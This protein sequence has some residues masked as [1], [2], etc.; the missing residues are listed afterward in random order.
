M[1]SKLF[2]FHFP[3][4]IFSF[5][6]LCLCVSAVSFSCSSKPTNLRALVP[7]DALVYLE[8]NDL[9]AALQPIIDS[10]PFGEVAKSKPDLSA[11]RGVQL[12]VAVTGFETKE[13]KITE[14]NSIGRIQPHFAAIA[15]THA[16]SWQ[17]RNFA[18]NQ[19][20]ELINNIYGGGVNLDTTPKNGGSYYVWTAEDG[21]KA[22]ALVDGSL[23]FFGNDESSIEKC[24]AVKR[25]EADSILK[26]SKLPPADPNSLAQGYVSTDG[27]AQIANIVGIAMASQTGEEEEVKSFIASIL[28]QILRSSVIDVSW[29][30]TKTEQGIEDKYLIST[31]PDVT[32]V[33]SETMAPSERADTLLLEF[34]P[35]NAP[36]VTLY[37]LKD[38]QVAWRSVLLVIQKQTD[39]TAGKLLAGFSSSLFEPYGIRDPE[40]F[41]KSVGPTIVSAKVDESGEKPVVIA[42]IKKVGELQRS[43][44]TDVGKL[45]NDS[46][47]ATSVQSGIGVSYLNNRVHLGDAE[48]VIGCITKET[49]SSTRSV[50][51]KQQLGE[52]KAS[53][54]T[55]GTDKSAASDIASAFDIKKYENASGKSKFMIETRFTKNGI[56]RKTVSDFGLI[57]S[58]IAQLA[59]EE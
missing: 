12:A 28:P 16:W 46:P 58:I 41:L 6:A 35:T 24:L 42:P 15:D 1:F 59:P 54:V 23:I 57:G 9:G 50:Q 5:L 33:L 52:A 56:E 7:S 20:G 14:E 37:N 38:P 21:R 2:I 32:N 4:S 51:L 27:V 19:L 40:L 48:S 3:F 49:D 29:V 13:E 45:S 39:S 34:L 53:V 31:V 10:K 43:I 22:Y 11:L 17:T 25:G 18:E 8:T 30:A 26:N 47:L 55:I 36:S 44:A